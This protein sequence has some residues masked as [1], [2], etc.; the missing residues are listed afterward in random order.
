MFYIFGRNMP[1]FTVGQYVL[2]LVLSHSSV[3][4]DII[5]FLNTGNFISTGLS[6][7]LKTGCK[8]K[9]SYAGKMYSLADGLF[10]MG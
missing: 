1:S 7:I 8:K 10:F 5:C 3:L 9:N 4:P 6:Y 2:S